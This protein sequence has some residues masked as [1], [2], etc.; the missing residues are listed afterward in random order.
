MTQKIN[1]DNLESNNLSNKK[2]AC[3]CGACFYCFINQQHF[4]TSN[5]G[6]L[7][8]PQLIIN[9]AEYVGPETTA[10]H[11]TTNNDGK[12]NIEGSNG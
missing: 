5:F 8:S 12:T 4:H 11:N 1:V 6:K 10:C 9:V 7:R 2:R 3:A